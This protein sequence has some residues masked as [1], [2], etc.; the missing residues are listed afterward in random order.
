MLWVSTVHGHMQV[1]FLFL[2]SQRH[3]SYYLPA[4]YEGVDVRGTKKTAEDDTPR[5]W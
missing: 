2:K 3:Q 5:K 1:S 4:F